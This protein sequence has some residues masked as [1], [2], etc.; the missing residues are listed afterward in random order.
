[1]AIALPL[2]NLGIEGL[3]L[4]HAREH[5]TPQQAWVMNNVR[6][7]K[8]KLEASP[9]VT[10]F[11]PNT[12]SG[13]PLNIQAWVDD[14]GN[15]LFV[16][17]TDTKIYSVNPSTLALTDITNVGG[18]YTGGP[19]GFWDAIIFQNLLIS[20]NKADQIQK[21]DGVA[22]NVVDLGGSP[23]KAGTIAAL[24][25][26]LLIADTTDADG[27]RV[28]RWPDSGNAEG[29]ALGGSSDEGYL[30]VYQGPGAILKLLQ[31]GEVVIGYRQSSVHLFFYIGPPF[32]IGQRQLFNDHGIIGRRAVTTLNQRH[33]YWGS[34]NVYI[35]DGAVPTPIATEVINDMQQS[36]DPA[37]PDNI[38]L[39]VDHT[40]RC[41]YFCYPTVG[42]IGVPTDA[43]VWS[44]QD[45]AWWNESLRATCSGRSHKVTGVTWDA[46]VGTWDAATGT[47]NAATGA[48][49]TELLLIGTDDG[50]I[51]FIDPTTVDV[52]G[53]AKERILETGLFE[54]ASVLWQKP[55]ARCTLDRIE[56][57]FEQKGDFNLEVWV[58]IQDALTGDGGISWTRFF[59][60]SDGS[61]KVIPTR[62]SGV[63]FSFRVRTTGVA[64]PFRVSDLVPFFN[65]RGER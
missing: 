4:N 35:F 6:S 15:T 14:A 29:W 24:L 52:E 50:K 2:N 57:E 58:G 17:L 1:M 27:P 47:W 56:V 37:Y 46:A 59:I 33:I 22:A 65:L 54:V 49:G 63:F 44:Y 28:V 61:K 53:L 32:I 10:R 30:I 34:D 8:G 31:M 60:T 18:D 7:F 13:V 19:G 11:V 48:A 62:L 21:W 55:G 38:H 5:L 36:F 20:T 41:V 39:F 51:Q 25:T 43:W 23:P 40:T 64:Q 16:I 12:V 26:Y 3:K 42:S 45:N 9:G